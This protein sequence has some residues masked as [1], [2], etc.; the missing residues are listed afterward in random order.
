MR[1]GLNEGGG[2]PFSG[3]L[4]LCLLFASTGVCAESVFVCRSLDGTRSYQDHACARRLQQSQLEIAAAPPPAASP[5]YALPSA[6]IST[7]R[8]RTAPP[9]ARV[10]EAASYECRADNGEV[11]YRHST[12]PRSIRI[13]AAQT[14]GTTRRGGKAAMASVTGAV[15]QR[16]DACKRIRAS[17]FSGRAGHE[18]DDR[19][20]TY[21]RNSGRDPC[22]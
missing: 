19:V 5:D 21:E 17:G 2:K 18:R 16:N 11:F 12:C 8:R 13:D 9:A 22:R 15:V 14:A 20:S 1:K 7:Q 4:T 6:R 3:V 10:H